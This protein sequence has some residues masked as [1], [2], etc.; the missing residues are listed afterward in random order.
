MEQ[1]DINVGVFWRE[2]LHVYRNQHLEKWQNT[3]SALG[4]KSSDSFQ[5]Y[6]M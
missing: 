5:L 4:A 2:N 6:S 3:W 1:D